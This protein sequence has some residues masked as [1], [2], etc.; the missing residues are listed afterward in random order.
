MKFEKVKKYFLLFV[1]YSMVGWVMEILLTIVCL[2][3]FVNRGV[4]IG[5][6][7]PIYGVGCL[8]I[9]LLVERFK[10]RPL[11]LVISSMLICSSLEYATSFL[12]ETLFNTRWWDYSNSFMNLNGRI[13]LSTT[14]LFGILGALIVYVINP[15][16][17]N[18]IDKMPV[19]MINVLFYFFASIMILDAATSFTSVSLIR[20]SFDGNVKD[21]TEEVSK[22]VLRF[23]SR[24]FKKIKEAVC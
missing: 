6:Y 21:T 19:G 2:K 20:N 11:L 12:L 14:V 23:I 15:V 4:L 22:N 7:L 1:M 13:C 17:M 3:K 18:V 5:P 9:I 10:D 16:F 24:I 8:L